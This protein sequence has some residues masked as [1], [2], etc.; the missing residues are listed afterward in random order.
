M[1]PAARLLLGTS[2][3]SGSLIPRAAALGGATSSSA[4]RLARLGSR[5][6]GSPVS[7]GVV[8]PCGAE[9]ARVIS[10]L[11]IATQRARAA[12]GERG[13][14]R[15]GLEGEGEGWVRVRF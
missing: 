4:S 6:G 1:P 13:A 9:E 2:M 7:P 11:E 10:P 5:R 3:R 15:L 12:R 8:S 14:P